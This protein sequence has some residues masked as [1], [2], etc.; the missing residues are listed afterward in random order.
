MIVESRSRMEGVN[1]GDSVTPPVAIV[2]MDVEGGGENDTI[3]V[4]D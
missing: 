1:E 4:D 2:D 3:E